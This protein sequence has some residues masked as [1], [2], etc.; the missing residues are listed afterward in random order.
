MCNFAL[1]MRRSLL[2]IIT[3]IIAIATPFLSRGQLN[4]D[5]MLKV[6]QNA[7]YFEDYVL[8]IQYFNQIIGV[9]PY[10]AQP[11]VLRAIAKY[12][13]EDFAGASSD[14]STALSINPFLPDAWEVKGVANQN[15][16]NAEI[17]IECY[18]KALELLPRNRQIM[19]NKAL[20]LTDISSYEA[21]DSTFKQLLE[22]YPN[23]DNGYIGRAKNYLAMGDT[24]AASADIDRALEINPNAF[25]GYVLRSAI[26][27]ER[28][29]DFK[30]ALEDMDK[31]IKLA[32]RY[33]GLY[34]NRAFLRYSLDDY[35]GAMADYDYA[36]ELEPMNETALFNRS[37]L[38][39]EV[40]DYEK[41][42]SDLNKILKL[43]PN[44]ERAHF[45]RAVSY[46][47]LGNYDKAIEDLDAVISIVPE[48]S[49]AYFLRSEYYR[50]KGDMK[51]AEA[52]YKKGMAVAKSTPS[53]TATE[54][55]QTEVSPEAAARRFNALIT[56]ENEAPINEE[57]NNTAIRGRV[58]DKSLD[59]ELQPLIELSYYSSPNELSSNVYY[60]KDVDDINA[61]RM[62]RF[63]IMVVSNPLSLND[64]E[65]ISRHFDSIEYYNSYLSTHQPRAIDYIGRAMDF[66]TVKNYDS[67]IEDLD[68]AILLTPNQ[69]VAYMLR[70][71]ARYHNRQPNM[72]NAQRTQLMMI[73]DD[74]N[75]AIE[76]SPRMA[77]VWF[78]KGNL[79]Y[80]LGDYTSA[81]ASYTK[82]IELSAAMGE[83]YYNRGF[84][85][86]KMGN[87]NAGIADLS[88]AGELGIIPAYNLLKRLNQ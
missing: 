15:I 48:L 58:Q 27:I 78:N 54:I 35:F 62:L 87:Q 3:F 76:I 18:D 61:T 42:I 9:K 53:E 46:A 29:S 26:S 33:A 2:N 36:L 41:A 70:A 71:Q 77:P 81:V 79:L 57:Y 74:I 16:G 19:F 72:P 22:A 17:A 51:K 43:N 52:D 66:I 75:R 80:E 55:E 64:S 23:F 11:Y 82:A 50:E 68:R 4:T 37:L 85:Y 45:N 32:P 40:T 39:I 24:L 44:Q 88:K 86:L 69:P 65:L 83:A 28:K 84:I 21:A 12:N 1:Y 20:A 73:L 47:N 5:Q 63:I 59:I 25:N 49:S 10:L 38:L 14:A 34:I 30:R 6:G 31:A 13:L 7:L 56:I 8:S 67:A 60:I